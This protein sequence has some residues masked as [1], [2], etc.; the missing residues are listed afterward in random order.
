MTM[1]MKV[2]VKVEVEVEVKVK[3]VFIGEFDGGIHVEFIAEKR[4][5]L[6]VQ[7]SCL[8]SLGYI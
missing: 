5:F 7:L 6:S 8:V 2:K 1:M 4:S 3:G